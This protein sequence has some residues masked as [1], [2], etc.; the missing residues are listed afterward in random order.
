MQLKAP[1]RLVFVFSLVCVIIMVAPG[2][3]GAEEDGLRAAV[4]KIDITPAK[5]V[6]LSGYASR[7][8]LSQGIHD[9]LS[10]RAVVFEEGGR[11]LVLVS[12][13]VIGF[14][15]N[16]A[17]KMRQA[18]LEG[19]AL[20][21]AEL[22][23]SAIHT[24]SA[25]SV[26]LESAKGH[27]NNLE[28]STEL[29]A[30]LIEVVKTALAGLKPAQVGFGAGSSPVGVNRREVVRNADGTTKIVLGRN[31]SGPKD[32]EVQV[33]KL[34]GA[35]SGEPMA[36]IFAYATHS[37]ALGPRNYVI[38]GDIHGLAEQFLEGFLGRGIVA[39]A[40]AGA[41]G[42]IDPWYRVVPG[43]NTTNGWIPEPVLLGTLLGEEVA[44]V[45]ERIQPFDRGGPVSTV[46]RTVLLPAKKP[47]EGT[48]TAARPAVL[49]FVIS[50]GRVGKVAFL[51]WGGEVFSELGKKV[52]ETSPFTHTIIL[53]H[54][55]GAAG[56][57]PTASSY[58][59]GGYE[60]QTSPYAPE[61]A[62][63]LVIAS[64]EVLNELRE[65]ESGSSLNSR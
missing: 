56:Y 58:A 33:L 16:T 31:P 65:G 62:E 1:L 32:E 23:L 29:Q 10:A 9:P 52:K 38:S 15:G 26:T 2:K 28:Y 6:T 40:F 39:P 8:N 11:R 53:T 48:N 55:N 3:T 49:P 64:L 24:H 59:E 61:A 25:P 19:C 34:A 54:C 60:V 14:Y 7:T 4:A 20:Q 47:R 37:T 17:Q 50:G 46:Q 36:A 27:P 57:V 45:W 22:F 21:P 35:P 44:Q 13:D 51:G 18:I 12:T 5:P 63:A 43:F 42:N 30:K 41:S